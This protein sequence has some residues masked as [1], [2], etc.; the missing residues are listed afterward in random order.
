MASALCG[1]CKN[2][3]HMSQRWGHGVN[4]GPLENVAEGTFTCDNCGRASIAFVSL[5]SNSG[6]QDAN[7]VNTHVT[8]ARSTVTWIPLVGAVGEFEDV[9]EPIRSSASEAFACSS[10]GASR[11]AILMARTVIEATAKAKGITTGN[12]VAK[13]DALRDANLIRPDVAD[14]AHEVRLMGNDMAHGDH[15][16]AVD[17]TEADEILE[18]M[19][20]VLEE[21]FQAP[22]R[23]AARRARRQQATQQ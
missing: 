16:D 19:A 22:A 13:I 6:Q 11:A 23:L 21:V 4:L 3:S 7:S 2:R 12:L 8:A 1:Y 15:L 20:D 5:G 17:A 9:P 10:I 18:L 14:A